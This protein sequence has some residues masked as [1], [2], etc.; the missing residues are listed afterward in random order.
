MRSASIGI[1]LVH[2]CAFFQ[3][4][5]TQSLE[6]T[7]LIAVSP[8]VLHV[9]PEIIDLHRAPWDRT[10]VHNGASVVSKVV[11]QER[12]DA[13]DSHLEAADSLTCWNRENIELIGIIGLD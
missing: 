6:G 12:K 4:L 11:E 13:R 10:P 8:H 3:V 7:I 5:S 2:S 9:D 1:E